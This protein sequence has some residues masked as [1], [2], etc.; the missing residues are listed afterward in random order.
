[1]ISGRFIGGAV[2]FLVWLMRAGAGLEFA[3]THVEVEAKAG[4]TRAELV[5]KFTNRGPGPVE[6]TKVQS[7]CECT[8]ARLAKTRYAPGESGEIKAVFEFEERSGEQFKQLVVAT[9]D[10]NSP[11]QRL[12][13]RVLIPE[14]LQVRPAAVFWSVRETISR[15]ALTVRVPEGVPAAL[16]LRV[17]SKHP[18]LKLTFG[19][20]Q[21]GR[22]YELRV[23]PRR[24]DE[25][26]RE[27]IVLEAKFAGIGVRRGTAY[28]Y[29]K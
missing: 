16:S 9:D 13:F 2:V 19:E 14:Y 15:R 12:S 3:R 25:R 29:V 18:R 10:P 27:E 1:M 4:D 7:S 17:A 22:V 6:I 5:F 21:K 23:E 28:V 24:L 20:V 11:V 26:F 8:T